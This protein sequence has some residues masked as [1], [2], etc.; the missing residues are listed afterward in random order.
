NEDAEWELPGERD[1]RNYQSWHCLVPAVRQIIER[2]AERTRFVRIERF[3]FRAYNR[4]PL[5]IELTAINAVEEAVY[6]NRLERPGTIIGDV[7]TD[8][9]HALL[10]EILGSL[11]FHIAQRQV[12]N[13]G[14]R[15]R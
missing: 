4:H 10:H 15:L 9:D 11:H 1:L 7:A 6:V 5:T 12:A 8:L 14:A 2:Q 3:R 13:I